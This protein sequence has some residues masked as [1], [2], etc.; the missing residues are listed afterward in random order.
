MTLLWNEYC[1]SCHQAKT[2]PYMYTQ[3]CEKY[4]HWARVTRATMRIQHKPGEAMQVDWAGTTIPYF[5]S[6]TAFESAAYLFVAVL[7]F[8]GFTYVEACGDMK[9]ENWLLC[10][11]HAYSYF[12]GS[13][14]LLIPDNLKT[15]VTKNTRYE[16]IL[17]TSYQELAQHYNTAI[18]P[19]RVAK[20][21]DKGAVEGGVRYSST[22]ITAALRNQKFF[23]LQEVQRAVRHQA[24]GTGL[25]TGAE[26]LRH[27]LHSYH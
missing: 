6:V 16:T 23:T 11:A 26:P 20:P 19:T 13:T 25:W 8:S 2:T 27:A 24:T 22:W 10:H 12:G 1:A 3:F 5:D 14:R 7:P 21:Q 4:R 9:S 17:N 15:G 18:V